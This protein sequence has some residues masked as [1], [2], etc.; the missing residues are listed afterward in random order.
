MNFKSNVE[1][2]TCDIPWPRPFR[3]WGHAACSPGTDPSFV[4]H[5][6]PARHCTVSPPSDG[7]SEKRW[8][9]LAAGAEAHGG[10]T[11]QHG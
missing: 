3:C 8:L 1:S 6:W 7:Y 11:A 2:V 10:D 4:E 9:V 5:V